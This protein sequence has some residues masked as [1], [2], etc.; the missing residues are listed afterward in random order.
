MVLQVPVSLILVTC[1]VTWGLYNDDDEH[2]DDQGDDD[3]DD[4][5]ND[6]N[7]EDNDP[8]DVDESAQYV[9]IC[10]LGKPNS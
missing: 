4:Y 2:N 8:G 10:H 6:D 3:Y 5:D 9:G 7:F 1:S